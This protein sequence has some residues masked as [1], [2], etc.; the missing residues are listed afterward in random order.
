MGDA[1]PTRL[2]AARTTPRELRSFALSVGGILVALAAVLYYGRG[3]PIAGGILA[4][5]GGALVVAGLLAPGRLGPVY[6]A[7]MTLAVTISKVTTPLLMGII[8]FGVLT[9]T[10]VVTRLLGRDALRRQRGA[11]TYWV[12]RAA[13]ARR[14]DL[15]R[16]F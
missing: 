3:R 12:D 5:L 13:G 15:R 9:P 6:R 2:T 1:A 4:A 16:Q 11:S 10:G 8:F 14:S 7:W